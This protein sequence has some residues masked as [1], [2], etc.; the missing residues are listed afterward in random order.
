MIELRGIGRTF[1]VGGRP[2][3]AL[4]DVDER[5]Q[6]GEHVAIMGPSGSGKS[7]LLNIL[8]C[9]DRPS[10]GSYRL[11]GREVGDM[12]EDEL[13]RIRR[14]QI[15]F[16]FQFFHLIPRLTAAGNVELPLLFDGTARA[17]R[18][19]LV[20]EAL[21]SV[22]LAERARHRPDQLSGGEMQRVAIARA[23]VTR[24]KILLADEP[25]GNLD[26]RSGRAILGLLGGMNAKGLTLIVV[27]HNPSVARH[28]DRIIVLRDGRV[29][30]R[31]AGSEVGGAR[32]A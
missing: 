27:T 29:A 14:H 26:S 5:I 30:E 19:K 32:I 10:Q 8:G 23:T 25:T 22:G 20:A 18:G 11:D 3:Y 4:S 2:V 7:T 6:D 1:Q 12:R 13:T 21:S 31:M 28:A 17:D 16:V 24:P 15:G 9:L